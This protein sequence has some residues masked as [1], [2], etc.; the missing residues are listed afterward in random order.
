MTGSVSGGQPAETKKEKV[1]KLS[2]IFYSPEQFRRL[3]KCC[4]LGE[5]KTENR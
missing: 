5:Q 4:P 1:A 2:A 3:C